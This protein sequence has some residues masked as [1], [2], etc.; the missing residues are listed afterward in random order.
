[1]SANKEDGT[2][3]SHKALDTRKIALIAVF[4]A[5]YVVGSYLPGFPMIGVPGSKIDL[6]RA[7]EVSYGLILGPV[8]GPVAAFMGAIIG[9][10]LS[11]GGVGVF[12]TP[13]APLTAFMVA[14]IGRRRVFGCKGWMIGSVVLGALIVGWFITDAGRAVPYYSGMHLLGLAVVLVFRDR[15]SGDIWSGDRRRVAVGTAVTGF[16]STVSGHMLGNLIYIAMFSPSPLFFATLLP[17]SLAERLVITAIST[18]VST[19]LI[20]VIMKTYPGL[21]ETGES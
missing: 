6:V 9:K 4:A 20:L 18:M 21:I 13:L 5:I 17:V 3:V 19:S 1:M 15:V 11:G 2:Q 8:W 12:F 7:L 16:A 14:V 10:I